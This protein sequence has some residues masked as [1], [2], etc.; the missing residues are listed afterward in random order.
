MK[1]P[2]LRIRKGAIVYDDT[3]AQRASEVPRPALPGSGPFVS[4]RRRRNRGPFTYIPLLVVALGLFVVFRVVP[5]TPVSRAVLAG[6]EI[7]LRVSPYQDQLIVGVTF[8]SRVPPAESASPPAAAV[9]VSIPGTG[10]R[11]L[12]TGRLEKSPMTLSGELARTSGAKKV[13]AEVSIG[14]SH[15][16][17]W[18]PAP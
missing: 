4:R 6:W 11:M 7:I 8:I 16:T 9:H 12:L 15:A 10:G 3:D 5:R 18:L 13:Q 14:D 2:V 1:H 17:L